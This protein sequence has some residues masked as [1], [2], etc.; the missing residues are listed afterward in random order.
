MKLEKE[1]EIKRR[2]NVASERRK[3][4]SN[5]REASRS[6]ALDKAKILQTQQ[7][8]K[9]KDPYMM[10]D[11]RVKIS[12]IERRMNP[13]TTHRINYVGIERNSVSSLA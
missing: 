11:E 1:I 2:K 7:I 6:L 13:Q 4:M 12:T 10:F 9:S 3:R 8:K 5:Q